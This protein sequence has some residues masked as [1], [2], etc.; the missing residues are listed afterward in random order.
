M[1][2]QINSLPLVNGMSM[3]VTSTGSNGPLKATT[4]APTPPSIGGPSKVLEQQQH[5]WGASQ[6]SYVPF[7]MI[8]PQMQAAVVSL[9]PATTV[10]KLVATTTTAKGNKGGNGKRQANG[11][12][13]TSR[14]AKRKSAAATAAAAT[15]S[16]MITPQTSMEPVMVKGKGLGGG[17]MEVSSALNSNSNY[18]N[19]TISAVSSMA[20]ITLTNSK[21]TI[22]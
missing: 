20:S 5:N 21:P 19:G 4:V 16:V 2:T 14:A 15:T 22:K 10:G 9:A 8:N 3:G 1:G 7:Q 6:H 18:L 12:A 13:N 11:G 17:G